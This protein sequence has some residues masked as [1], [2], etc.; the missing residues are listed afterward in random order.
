MTTEM[1]TVELVPLVD[2][3]RSFAEER[4]TSN[5]RYRPKPTEGEREAVITRIVGEVRDWLNTA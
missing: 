3:V 5:W 2:A 4:M 1:D